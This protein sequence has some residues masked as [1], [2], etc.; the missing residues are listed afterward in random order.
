VRSSHIA[1]GCVEQ[2]VVPCDGVAQ[3]A[4]MQ[5]IP[6]LA[7]VALDKTDD[8]IYR[9]LSLGSVF[10]IAG[11]TLLADLVG[12]RFCG[13]LGATLRS[14]I[15]LSGPFVYNDA[16]TWGPHL[17]LPFL[18][19]TLFV[20]AILHRRVLAR[21]RVSPIRSWVLFI[22]L[23]ATI[24]AMGV[25]ANASARFSDGWLA[26]FRCRGATD[27]YCPTLA[28]WDQSG[29]YFNCIGSLL[30][31]RNG[32]IV[33]VQGDGIEYCSR[34]YA[35]RCGIRYRGLRWPVVNGQSRRRVAHLLPSSLMQC[36]PLINPLVSVVVPVFDEEATLV[37][38]LDR[39]LELDLRIEII[40]S[41]DGSV[42]A[43]REIAASYA[44][45]G[46]ILV[47]SDSNHGKGH[48]IRKAFL[49][50]TGDI[51]LIQD[52]D[53]EYD[54]SDIGKLVAPIISG[55]ADV[56]FGTRFRGG[57]VQRVHLFWHSVG[58]RALTL[59][60]NVL[61]NSTLTDMEVGYKAFRGDLLR[62]FRFTSDDFRIEPEM[63]AGML[64]TPG[65]RIYEVPIAYYGR[66][67]DE[68]KKI[69]WRDGYRALG[70]LI[71]LRVSPPKREG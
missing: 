24:V 4:I 69:T 26:F 6:A 11:L 30:W 36:K 19:P 44:D 40:V 48:A 43:S 68:G 27:V 32:P 29:P 52:A 55:E 62:S 71:R 63:T 45:R 70:A 3:F 39:L 28:S 16:T 34:S 22:P 14:A 23:A 13:V 37:K 41:D 64:T 46:V 15:V 5:N 61:F 7:G 57:E 50:S 21:W 49:Q 42:D 67:F 10:V 8:T 2:R 54:P 47:G 18:L 33:L 58:N 59:I 1:W 12:R 51:V 9:V 65:L 17:M 38:V 60:T 25:Y 20:G 35:G 53:L 56:V 31:D 66:S